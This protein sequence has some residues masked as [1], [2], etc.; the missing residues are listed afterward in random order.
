MEAP[1]KLLYAIAFAVFFP[2]APVASPAQS[3]DL[4]LLSALCSDDYYEDTAGRCT[5]ISAGELLTVEAILAKYGVII[6][7]DTDDEVIV[8]YLNDLDD[9]PVGSIEPRNEDAGL[10]G[11]KSCAEPANEQETIAS[12]VITLEPPSEIGGEVADDIATTGPTAR[13]IPAA[14]DP[15]ED[16]RPDRMKAANVVGD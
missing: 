12:R 9:I 15:F 11:D 6:A 8:F 1:V 4:S 3:L 16:N 14:A 2:A 10:T 5:A 7:S 13:S